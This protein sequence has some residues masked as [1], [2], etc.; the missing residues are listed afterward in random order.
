M[1]NFAFCIRQTHIVREAVRTADKYT[2]YFVRRQAIDYFRRTSNICCEFFSREDASDILLKEYNE[3]CVDYAMLDDGSVESPWTDS[4]YT[5]E[6]F[7]QT[8]FADSFSKLSESEKDEL[9]SIAEEKYIEKLGICEDYS[10]ALLFYEFVQEEYGYIPENMIPEAIAASGSLEAD[11]DASD[12]TD[13]AAA[14]LASSGFKSSGRTAIDGISGATFYEG[15]YTLYGVTVDCLKYKSGNY[16]AAEISQMDAK[17]AEEH[18]SWRK[19]YSASAKY[20]C[21]SYAW[22]DASQTN[23]YWLNNPDA[24]ANSSSFSYIGKNGSAASGDR[25]II[26]GTTAGTVHSLISTSNGTNSLSINTTSKLGRNGVYDAPLIDM[27]I[28]YV[29]VV[30]A[31]G[32]MGSSYYEVYR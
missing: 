28:H 31:T 21:H 8:Y 7:L 30:N 6:L 26:R 29:N 17:I 1:T 27:M 18:P 15:T 32:S 14:A 25:I 22:I 9:K 23:V 20:N 5:K 24:F 2:A 13:H 3:L 4:G 10:T 16:S 12:E 19:V 11:T